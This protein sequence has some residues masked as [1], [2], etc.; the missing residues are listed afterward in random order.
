MDD[1]YVDNCCVGSQ[2]PQFPTQFF[3]SPIKKK[4]VSSGFPLLFMSQLP[5]PPKEQGGVRYLGVAQL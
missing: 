5:I 2:R 1:G 3:K 4:S